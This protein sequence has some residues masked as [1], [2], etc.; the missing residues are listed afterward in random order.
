MHDDIT[1]IYYCAIKM[2][3]SCTLAGNVKGV[4]KHV[5]C[6]V[7]VYAENGMGRTCSHTFVVTRYF[8]ETKRSL[9]LQLI[10]N[11]S[12][13]RLNAIINVTLGDSI[14]ITP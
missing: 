7:T 14:G 12:V 2:M 6:T 9:F 1:Y 5:V 3:S 8:A 11:I 10:I 4:M 13:K